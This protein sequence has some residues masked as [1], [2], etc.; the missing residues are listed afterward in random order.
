MGINQTRLDIEIAMN[1]LFLN[2]A[3][4]ENR[5]I[6]FSLHRRC[7]FSVADC[8]GRYAAV[9]FVNLTPHLSAR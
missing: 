2:I 7:F 6:Q 3:T 1:D 9:L 4:I 8:E 5:V